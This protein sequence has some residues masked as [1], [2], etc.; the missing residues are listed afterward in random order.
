VE[1]FSVPGGFY[2]SYMKRVAKEVGYRAVLT[3]GMGINKNGLSLY[4]LRRIAI[5][6]NITIEKFK[7]IIEKGQIPAVDKLGY[8]SKRTLQKILGDRRYHN[9]RKMVLPQ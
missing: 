1:Y 7:F 6:K 3:S 9:F 5:R 2:N 4:Y 8:F